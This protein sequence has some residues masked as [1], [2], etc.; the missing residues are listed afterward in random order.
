M[1]ALPLHE[2]L[3]ADVGASDRAPAPPPPRPRDRRHHQGAAPLLE[4]VRAYDA[5]AFHCPGHKRGRGAPADLVDLV[6]ERML[7]ADVWLETGA[8]DRARRDAES[9]A[10]QAWGAARSYLLGNG[11]TS[12]N[13]AFLLAH[14]RDGDSAVVS[15]NLHTST[16]T[17][18]VLSGARPVWVAP[19]ADP[20]SGSPGAVHPDDVAA[21]LREHPGAVLVSVVSP[22]YDGACSDTA[23]V[24]R[25]ARAAGALC[26]V[27]EAWGPHLPFHPDLP[28]HAMA[29]GADGA[30]TSV[31]KLLPALSSGS[32]LHAGPRVDVDRLDAVVRATQTTS[33]LLPL[34]VS[35]DVARREMAVDGRRRVQ[36]ALDAAAQAREGLA[37]VP[38]LRLR[39]TPGADPLKVSVDVT[40]LGITGFVAE[41]LLRRSCRLAP[42]G[43]DLT[44]V[45]LVVST[46]DDTATVGALVAAFG[47]LAGLVG[48]PDRRAVG[49]LRRRA[50]ALVAAPPPGPAATTPRQAF[51][52]RSRPVPLRAAV[53]EVCAELVTPYPPGVPVVAPGELVTAAAVDYLAEVVAAGAHVH[54]SAD[55][56]LRTVRV[57][58]A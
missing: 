50:R 49:R 18:L 38:G 20:V 57:L 27:D 23:G 26:Y 16:L 31:H 43:A 35:V 4:A 52:G 22:G 14:L 45:H 34:L 5:V 3:P 8:Y 30:V 37:R 11:S 46:A 10:A 1:T 55:R 54:G 6:G 42:E 56:S 32:L 21:A 12:G 15:R 29:V 44:R 2:D 51:L 53:G 36:Q 41:E 40:G 33:P 48:T 39:P 25:A 28:A 19:R 58:S 9:L 13:L 17:G 7:A 24:V 47:R